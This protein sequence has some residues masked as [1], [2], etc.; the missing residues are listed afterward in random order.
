MVLGKNGSLAQN[1][2][3]DEIMGTVSENFVD[4]WGTN[5]RVNPNVITSISTGLS[6]SLAKEE[7]VGKKLYLDVVEQRTKMLIN[8][9]KLGVGTN[10]VEE[11][12]LKSR[13][14]LI[15]DSGH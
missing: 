3:N 15:R 14:E 11:N 7:K 1:C 6:T 8:L 5:P 10:R 2:E 4:I 12:H 13:N 9:E